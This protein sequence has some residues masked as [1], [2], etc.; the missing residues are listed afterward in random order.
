MRITLTASTFVL[1]L[2]C[3]WASCA[4]PPAMQPHAGPDMARHPPA[5]GGMPAAA[6]APQFALAPT[7]AAAL[8]T[9]PAGLGLHVGQEAPDAKLVD[10]TGSSHS[11][12][13]LYGSG[14][15]VVLFYRGGWCPFCNLQL[16]EFAEAK[17]EFE[18]RGVQIVA[19]SVDQPSAEAKTQMRHGVP[20]LMLSDSRLD[21]H[22][23]FRV[24]H[25]PGAEERSALAGYGIDLAAYSGEMHGSFA[26]PA[27]FLVDRAGAVRFA[28]VDE[29]YKTRPSAAQM[30]A[31]VDRVFLAK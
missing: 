11:L 23:A 26:V 12:K 20:F 15:T 2:S 9:A 24:V 30:L 17:G 28:H 18:R 19:I 6:P 13:A 29:D 3:F 1:L 22:R 8:G 27:V 16:H 7:P 25:V 31:V 21:A 4:Q 5:A 14:P 10:V